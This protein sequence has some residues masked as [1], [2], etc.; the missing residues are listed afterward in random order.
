LE[1]V[2]L[3]PGLRNIGAN[4]FRYCENLNKLQY[5]GTMAQWNSVSKDSNWKNGI[6]TLEVICQDGGVSL[7]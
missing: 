6:A 1:S 3:R 2:V 5:A 7:E 4:L